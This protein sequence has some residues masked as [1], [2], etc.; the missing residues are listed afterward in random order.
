MSQHT[1]S[2][3]TPQPTSIEHPE[4]LV[5]SSRPHPWELALHPIKGSRFIFGLAKDRRVNVFIKIAYVG[6][7][8][9][10]LIAMLA[11]EGLLA[12]L[13]LAAFGLLGLF[14]KAIVSEHHARWFH[15]GRVAR[16]RR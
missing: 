15:P 7:L 3:L 11:P 8:A 13:G 16:G 9:L 4:A 6:I 12:V 5:G 10:L 1:P 14:P 2:N